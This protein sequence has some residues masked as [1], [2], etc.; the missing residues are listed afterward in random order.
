MLVCLVEKLRSFHAHENCVQHDRT[1]ALST[2]PTVEH[3]LHMRRSRRTRAQCV[4][5]EADGSGRNLGI[6]TQYSAD[7]RLFGDFAEL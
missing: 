4:G 5:V 1:I 7:C 6:I 3:L 2:H